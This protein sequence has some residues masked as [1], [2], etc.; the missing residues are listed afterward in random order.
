MIR[1]ELMAAMKADRRTT[2]LEK[3]SG[4]RRERRRRTSPK[5]KRPWPQRTPHK[6][7][8]PPQLLTMNEKE[9]AL[10]SRLNAVA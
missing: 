9:K 2:F 6:P 5:Q 8:K 10:L 4:C 1:K 3:L 7:P